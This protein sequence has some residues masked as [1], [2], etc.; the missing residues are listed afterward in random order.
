CR[1]PRD[2]LL[3]DGSLCAGRCLQNPCEWA[4]YPCVGGEGVVRH[5]GR[6]SCETA[7]VG[8]LNLGDRCAHSAVSSAAWVR[9]SVSESRVPVS[10]RLRITSM[11]SGLL[12]TRMNFRPSWRAASPVVP[13]P[14]KKSS[15]TSPG[16]LLA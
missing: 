6:K 3:S 12:S 15:T 16:W 8:V 5:V 10:S 2:E 14:A 7:D 11:A 9:N 1:P 13:L 4:T